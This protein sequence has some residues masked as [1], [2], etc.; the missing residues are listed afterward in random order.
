MNCL[1]ASLISGLI[2]VAPSASA[3]SAQEMPTLTVE[4]VRDTFQH[5]GYDTDE[6][7]YWDS[8]ALTT[9]FVRDSSFDKRLVLVLV[10]PDVETANTEHQAAHAQEEAER[11]TAFTMDDDNGPQLMQGYGRSAWWHNIA[12]M[13]ANRV[14]LSVTNEVDEPEAISTS[15]SRRAEL[16]K[17]A[18]VDADFVLTLRSVAAQ[19]LEQRF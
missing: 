4:Q 7:I 15:G 19:V 18:A 2:V 3:T 9:F 5:S 1:I 8:S 12:I 17:L 6:P 10:Y 14:V 13:Q 16:R 11:G